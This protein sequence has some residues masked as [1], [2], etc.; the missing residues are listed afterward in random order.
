MD[1]PDVHRIEYAF[2]LTHPDGGTEHVLDPAN[3]TRS[4][5]AFGDKSVVLLPGYEPPAWLDADLDDAAGD[6]R[7]L[8]DP[9]ARP[10]HRAAGSAVDPARRD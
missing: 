5:G 10:G 8:R 6:V 1:R 2:E 9:G 4:P 7:E 3:G